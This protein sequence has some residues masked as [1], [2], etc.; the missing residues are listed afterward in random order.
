[1]PARPKLDVARFHAGF[2]KHR[3]DRIHLFCAVAEFVSPAKVLYPGSYVDVAPSVFFDDVHYVDLDRRAAR[4]FDQEADLR[5]LIRDKRTAAGQPITDFSVQFEHA[6]YSGTLGAADGSVDLLVSLY[7]GFISESCTR[8]LS[9]G[10]HLFVNDS[11][12]DASMASLDSR[13]E[14]VAVVTSGG[15]RYRIS[16]AN[17]DGY[18]VPKRGGAPTVDELHTSGRGLGYTKSPYAYLF[19]WSGPD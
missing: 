18:L 3:D 5:R 19:R 2:D 12:G 15:G 7:A 4:F 6:D 1:M 13:Y 16:T 11:H 14:L 8:Y 9:P 17:L 10:G